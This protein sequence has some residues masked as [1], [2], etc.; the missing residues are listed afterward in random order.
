MVQDHH[1]PGSGGRYYKDDSS[2]RSR[3]YY[4]SPHNYG[5]YSS[6][7]SNPNP[8][9]PSSSSSQLQQQQSQSQSA[10]LNPFSSRRNDGLNS[11]A[12]PEI[13]QTQSFSPSTPSSSSP[14][15]YSSRNPSN[16]TG[17]W[18]HMQQ[19]KRSGPY[20]SGRP[21]NPNMAPSNSN[22]RNIP[23]NYREDLI[24]QQNS[25]Y[26]DYSGYID[27]YQHDH[28]SYSPSHKKSNF[29]K[30]KY[31]ASFTNYPK[32]GGNNGNTDYRDFQAYRQTYSGSTSGKQSLMDSKTPTIDSSKLRFEKSSSQ[33]PPRTDSEDHDVSDV[34]DN[35][36][37]LLKSNSENPRTTLNVNEADNKNVRSIIGKKSDSGAEIDN[38]QEN[39]NTEKETHESSSSGN[40]DS[41]NISEINKVIINNNVT[42]DKQSGDHEIPNGTS[43]VS[44]GITHSS[45]INEKEGLKKT[46]DTLL[47]EKDKLPLV[48]VSKKEI[49]HNIKEPDVKEEKGVATQSTIVPHVNSIKVESMKDKDDLSDDEQSEIEGC[50][51]PMLEGQYRAWILKHRPKSERRKNLKY[52]NKSKLQ[53]LSQYNFLDKSF[54]IFKQADA[55]ILFN[56]LKENAAFIETK[57]AKLTEHFTYSNY[58]W[59][60]DIAFYD[61]QLEKAYE[62]ENDN[63]RKP[64]VEEPNSSKTTSSRRSRHHGDSVRTEAEFMEILASLEQERERDPLIRAQYGAAMIPNMIMNPIEKYAMTRKMDSNNLIRDKNAWA[65]RILSDPIDTFTEAEHSKFCELYTLY[66]KKFGR[67]SHE[68][69]GLRTPEECVL[70]YYKTKKTT[71]YKQLLANKNKKSKKKSSKK[72][73]ETKSRTEALTSDT[74]NIDNE[75]LIDNS[76]SPD[77]THITETQ[78]QVTVPVKTEDKKRKV[79]DL[80]LPPTKQRKVSETKEVSPSDGNDI[81]NDAKPDQSFKDESEIKLEDQT[82]AD[83]SSTLS[84]VSGVN[85]SLE[86]HQRSENVSDHT[87]QVLDENTGR[88]KKQ[89]KKDEEKPHI[90]SYWS[91]QDINNFPILLEKFGSRWEDIAEALGTKSATMVKNYYQRGL[92]EHPN[93]QSFLAINKLPRQVVHP[94]DD[95]DASV[96][97]PENQRRPSMGYFYKPATSYAATYPTIHSVLPI[98]Q[99]HPANIAIH[100]DNEVSRIHQV[101]HFVPIAQTAPLYSPYVA[102][103]N[104]ATTGS[105]APLPPSQG[106]MPVM[107]ARSGVMN[108]SS[109]LNA[110]SA[111]PLPLLPT[112]PQQSSLHLPP[113]N[114]HY[115]SAGPVTPQLPVTNRG[116]SILNLLNNDDVPSANNYEGAK[117]E[118]H[119]TRAIPFKPNISNIMNSPVKSEM[120]PQ[121][122]S[123]PV[124]QQQQQQQ[125]PQSHPQS[126]PQTQTQ[127]Q[128][129]LQPQP[130]YQHQSQSRSA[131]FTGGT[132]A[133]DALARIAFERK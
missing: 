67:I 92:V 32:N 118:L 3:K 11:S 22:R 113:L 98:G 83:V 29:G 88:G 79:E 37:N 19:S 129:Q 126:Q 128:P 26:S 2:R 80:E 59:H 62:N 111:S 94:S 34:I 63:S 16:S 46:E 108:M 4:S 96:L 72:K 93:W 7:S 89:K 42:L 104:P 75:A 84:H 99:Q 115:N 71:N 61:K 24:P 69:G 43:L 44:P 81:S 39:A 57:T 45:G 15:S 54:L 20:R 23:S 131:A 30:S 53:S 48:E 105:P 68:L 78:I 76:K 58:L 56:L 112:P 133:L 86:E 132:S 18:Y 13:Q 114:A 1:T 91:V 100:D 103:V 27:S 85:E 70:H 10:H 33:E 50:I 82:N 130:Q 52:L 64:K 121:G 12:N 36:E 73:K 35:E 55:F 95:N 40:N 106:P 5:P 101:P 21:S 120:P 116:P 110:N 31:N 77:D 14:S 51:F 117:N 60:K 65:Q 49:S 125:Q 17:N 124:Y 6:Y 87:T 66:P 107:A 127:T 47:P 97:Q 38:L 74:S 102:E 28:Y 123:I 109:L 119:T 8:F 9:P 90:S 25:R 41:S 122:L